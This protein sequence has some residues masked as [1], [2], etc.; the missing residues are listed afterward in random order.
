[1]PGD[2]DLVIGMSV[3][4]HLCAERGAEQTRVDPEGA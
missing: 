2:V 4:H 1:M 3:M